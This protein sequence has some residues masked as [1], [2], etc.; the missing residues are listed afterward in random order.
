MKLRRLVAAAAVATTVAVAAPA[1]TAQPAPEPL[2]RV[3]YE[4]YKVGGWEAQNIILLPAALS[5]LNVAISIIQSIVSAA[6]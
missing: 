3:L 4:I 6:K 2:N 5:S 1:A